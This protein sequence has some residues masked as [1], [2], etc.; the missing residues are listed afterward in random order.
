MPPPFYP[1][2]V[3]P[4]PTG[5]VTLITVQSV[6]PKAR[7]VSVVAVIVAVL[8]IKKSAFHVIT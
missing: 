7:E 6:L 2:P 8:Q 3:Q 5:V 1:V 4:V